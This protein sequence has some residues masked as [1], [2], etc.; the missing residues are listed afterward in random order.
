LISGI[1]AKRFGRDPAAVT[2]AK[3]AFQ[4][5]GHS[6]CHRGQ[7]NR[8]LRELGADPPLADYIAWLWIGRPAAEW[9]D[10]SGQTAG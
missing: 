5:T 4:V 7:V 10:G 6:T 3:T 9:A 8:R 2:L 1:S